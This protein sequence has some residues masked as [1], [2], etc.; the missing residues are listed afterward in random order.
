[1]AFLLLHSKFFKMKGIRDV[2][3]LFTV[4]SLF[5]GCSYPYTYDDNGSTI[6][7]RKAD[8]FQVLLEGDNSPNFNWKLALLPASIELLKTDK[9]QY[10]G[11]VTDYIFSFKTVAN[12][13]NV[14]ELIYTDGTETK[15][16]FKITVIVDIDEVIN[17][18]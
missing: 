8:P 10:K 13:N 1:M 5:M 4:L 9:V 2:A 3:A 12:G 14:V 6:E 16:T 17:S 11:R 18:E 15:K 7:L